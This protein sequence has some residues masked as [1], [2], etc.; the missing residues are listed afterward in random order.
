MS[1]TS[2]AFIPDGNRRFAF[3]S[4][5]NLTS[6]YSLGT[7]KALEVI[8]WLQDFPEIKAGTFYTLSLENLQRSKAE[9]SILFSLFEKELIKVQE[10]AFF[11]DRDI[12]LK[13][14]GRLDLLPKKIQSLAAKAEALTQDNKSKTIYLALAYN[15]QQEIIDA[16]KKLARK[17]AN[18]GLKLKDIDIGLFTNYLYSQAPFPDLIVRTSGT[19]RLSAFMTFQSAYSEL[20]F[21]N[22]H[23][24]ALT[25]QDL[26]KA[27]KDFNS[28]ERRFGK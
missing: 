25:R 23:W 26:G 14:V 1:L 27:V 24:P 7:R 5:K 15:G 22:K 28:R 17:Y 16:C 3:S 10:N 4:G 9:L 12:R 21:I 13:F 19:E 11:G 8:D 2:I 20:C 18:N 6:A